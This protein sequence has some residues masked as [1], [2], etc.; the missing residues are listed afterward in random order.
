MELVVTVGGERNV[1]QVVQ[2]EVALHRKHLGTQPIIRAA[3]VHLHVVQRMRHSVNG[4]YDKTKFGVLYVF[5]FS[6]SFFT[7]M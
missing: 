3:Y 1:Q 7:W 6:A 5:P 4:I 2:V